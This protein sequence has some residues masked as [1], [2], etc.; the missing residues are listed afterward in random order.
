MRQ[1]PEEQPEHQWD[2]D[3]VQNDEEDGSGQDDAD[4]HKDA[5]EDVADVCPKAFVWFVYERE[6][7][8]CV[9]VVRGHPAEQPGACLVSRFGYVSERGAACGVACRALRLPLSIWIHSFAA[10]EHGCSLIGIR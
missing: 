3:R 1:D 9:C 8:R 6:M 7:H 10:V 2:P 4:R 5:F